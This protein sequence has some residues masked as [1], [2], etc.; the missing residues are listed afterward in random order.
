MNWKHHLP[1]RTATALILTTQVICTY[2]LINA[3]RRDSAGNLHQTLQACDKH[4][5]LEPVRMR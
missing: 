1:L 3:Q 4:W 2:A 5:A